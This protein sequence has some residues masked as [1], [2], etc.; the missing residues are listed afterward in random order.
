M[1]N[2]WGRNNQVTRGGGSSSL[3]LP[4]V[5][6]LLLAA[7]GGYFWFARQQ[8]QTEIAALTAQTDS[9]RDELAAVT[10]EKDTAN[11]N[12]AELKRNSG[13]W[14]GELEKDY[15][16]LTLNEVPKLHRLLDKRD[17]DISALEKLLSTE[18]TAAKTAADDFTATIAGLTQ[19]LST[20][21]A[22]VAD[23]RTQV[24]NLST[25]KAA[26]NKQVTDLKAA[27]ERAMADTVAARKALEQKVTEAEKKPPTFKSALDLARDVQIQ[28]LEQS[29]ADERRKVEAL[30]TQLEDQAAVAGKTTVVPSDTPAIDKPV[31]ETEETVPAAGLKPRDRSMVDKIIGATRGVSLLDDEKKQRLKDRLVSGAC[32]TDALEDAF[33]RVPLILM[34]NLMRDFKSDC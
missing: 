26:L 21:K 32:V 34:R 15:A 13:S 31:A 16:D 6:C 29:L 27:V 1:S 33:G 20:A 30:E 17:A 7:A 10:A 5:L 9:L 14:A 3:L 19:Q 12:L 8:M 23:A 24:Q 2:Q 22:E 4:A 25:D 11:S 18:K 28:T